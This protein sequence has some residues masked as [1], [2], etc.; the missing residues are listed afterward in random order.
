MCVVIGYALG[1]ASSGLFS[2]IKFSIKWWH[3]TQHNFIGLLMAVLITMT[4]FLVLIG[5]TD[6]SKHVTANGSSHS[7]IERKSKSMIGVYKHVNGTDIPD[8]PIKHETMAD[9]TNENQEKQNVMKLWEILSDSNIMILVMLTALSSYNGGSGQLLAY[10]I[11]VF[12]FKL[13][14]TTL[15]II[16]SSSLLVIVFLLNTVLKNILIKTKN[17]VLPYTFCVFGLCIAGWCFILP[18]MVVIH[19]VVLQYILVIVPLILGSISFL[20]QYTLARQ[21]VYRLVPNNSR[22]FTESVREFICNQF[23]IS[24]YFYA[25]FI[26]TY[27]QYI[28]PCFILLLLFLYYLFFRKR[29]LYN[30]SYEKSTKKC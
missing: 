15:S 9:S 18:K 3:I 20:T 2:S 5:V 26:F 29:N 17:M 22:N 21:I 28:M 11:G 1:P 13:N 7:L 23:L 30:S 25:G 4:I 14:V 8:L 24:G 10:M 12:I 19:S 16:I 27:I 6:I